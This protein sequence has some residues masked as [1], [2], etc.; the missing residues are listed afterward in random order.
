MKK[1]HTRSD[2]ENYNISKFFYRE[3]KHLS[4]KMWI[5]YKELKSYK[6]KKFILGLMKK[7]TTSIYYKEI[8]YN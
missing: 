4:N 6:E 7:N 8:P 5:H 3:S 2:E 1:I